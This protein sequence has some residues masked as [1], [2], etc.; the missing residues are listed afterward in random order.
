MLVKLLWLLPAALLVFKDLCGSGSH[1]VLPST[2]SGTVQCR[3]NERI[4]NVR[5]RACVPSW[6][7]QVDVGWQAVDSM[8]S[9]RSF[10]VHPTKSRQSGWKD[11]F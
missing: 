7:A 3:L 10:Q 4:V 1:V 11:S 8:C 5:G 2:A 9:K 6:L